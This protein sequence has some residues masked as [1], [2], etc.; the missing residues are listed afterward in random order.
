M[1]HV[2]SLIHPEN[3]ASRRVAEKLGGT[4]DK[5]GSFR[6]HEILFYGYTAPPPNDL[7]T[8]LVSLLSTDMEAIPG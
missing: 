6:D 4:I 3:V 7:R 2:I 8:A 1:T 5:T